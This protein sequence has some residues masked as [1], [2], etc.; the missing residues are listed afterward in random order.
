VPE[1]AA[2]MDSDVSRFGEMREVLS[3]VLGRNPVDTVGL[4]VL[5]IGSGAILANALYRQPGPH[6]APIFSVKPRPVAT[7]LDAAP[8][9]PRARP[10][11]PVV[12]T[13][14]ELSVAKQDMPVVAKPE[15]VARIPS[16]PD[17]IRDVLNGVAPTQGSAPAQPAAPSPRVMQA[18]RA[19]ND[20][21]YGPV[22]STGVIDAATTAAVQKFE[23]ARKLQVTGQLT[24]KVIRE[25]SVDTGR[26]ID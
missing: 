11:A 19:L 5:L 16:R 3:R 22:K 1:R 24:P 8:P 7:G 6:P 10:A 25:I 4:F 2:T 15:S 17:P 9:L 20:F 18:Q 12:A 26:Q 21:G 13:K 14:P 23:R